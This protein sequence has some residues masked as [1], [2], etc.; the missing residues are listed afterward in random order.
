MG[1]GVVPL[2]LLKDNP[3]VEIVEGPL[4]ELETELWVLAH[5]D[6]R[7]LQRVKVLFEFLKQNVVLQ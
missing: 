3:Q 7:H 2:V 5:P 4:D 6:A 1:V